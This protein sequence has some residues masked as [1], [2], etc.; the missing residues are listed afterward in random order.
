MF[1]PS[2]PTAFCLPNWGPISGSSDSD[3]RCRSHGKGRTVPTLLRDTRAALGSSLKE[4]G[5]PPTPAIAWPEIKK[6][7]SFLHIYIYKTSYLRSC[8]SCSY[9]AQ[10]HFLYQLPPS[11][12]RNSLFPLPLTP[13][14]VQRELTM[15]LFLLESC[16]SLVLY[17]P[18]LFNYVIVPWQLSSTSSSLRQ[19]HMGQYQQT[20]TEARDWQ[21]KYLQWHSVTVVLLVIYQ[22]CG[23]RDQN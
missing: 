11:R 22:A 7:T 18:M 13:C 3:V 5:M 19:A 21:D 9:F 10:H 8:R 4:P 14:L 1:F 17:I 16:K 20:C 2:F 6:D 23:W 12:A 15:N